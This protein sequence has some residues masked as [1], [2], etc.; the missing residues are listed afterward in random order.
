M[1]KHLVI[2]S[3]TPTASAPV[4]DTIDMRLTAIQFGATRTNLF[5]FRPVHGGAVPEF[6]A[7]SHVDVYL[8]NGT[9]R[10]YSTWSNGRTIGRA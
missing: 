10:Q 4:D 9:I 1:T 7:G 5:E 2:S 8:P 6:S 3:D